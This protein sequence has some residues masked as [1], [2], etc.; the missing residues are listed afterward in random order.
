VGA[1]GT[2]YD[3]EGRMEITYNHGLEQDKNNQAKAYGILQGIL[4]AKEAN[5]RSLIVI[6][7]SSVVIKAMLRK[8]Y[9]LDNMLI[10][11]FT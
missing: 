7:Y 10:V 11:I 4:L 8:T 5:V 9:P 3:P 1:G 6:G 2:L